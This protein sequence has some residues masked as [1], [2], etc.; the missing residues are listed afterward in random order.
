MNEVLVARAG[1]LT[2]VQDLGRAGHRQS[3]VSV[4]GALDAHALRVA[5]LLVGNAP[6]AA[7]LEAGL[8][9]LHLRFTDDR[10]IAWCGGAF[11][12]DVAG[13]ILPSGQV[14]VVHGGEDLHLSPRSAG[15][16]AWLAVSGG[17]DVPI[18]LGSRATD[19]RARFGGFE[20]RVL[21]DGDA[22]KLGPR[23]AQVTRI[24]EKLGSTRKSSWSAPNEW[25]NTIRRHEFLRVVRGACWSRFLPSAL[26]A[27]QRE[28]FIVR[29]DSDQ[30]GVRLDG[31][32][33]MQGRPEEMLSEAVA[34]G[35]IQVPPGGQPIMLLGDCQTIGGYPKLAH[36][37]TV[38]IGAAAQ[39]HAGDSVR[40]A[41]VT[42]TDAQRWLLER[43]REVERFRI[44]LELQTQ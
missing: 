31:P 18:V 8:G 23:S 7:G 28:T 27:F 16:R 11:D 26:A 24:A 38:D 12:A 41:E 6:G 15:G 36:V 32:P 25:A 17:V 39:L 34:P 20:G 43:E 40:F 37:I 3:G 22:V 21:Q 29:P 44:G 13:T 4:G 35:T 9:K 14:A 19:R 5:N 10:L 42:L 1:F 2:T 33:L 30:M